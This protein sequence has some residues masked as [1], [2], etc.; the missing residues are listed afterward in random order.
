MYAFAAAGI[1]G[2]IGKP[3][4]KRLT[5]DSGLAGTAPARPN[6]KHDT[7]QHHDANRHHR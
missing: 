3:N 5:P 6:P 1:S 2:G 7:P 4:K